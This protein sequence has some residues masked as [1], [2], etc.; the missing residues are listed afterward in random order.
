MKG[1]NISENFRK[2]K[3]KFFRYICVLYIFITINVAMLLNPFTKKNK[4]ESINYLEL[5]PAVKHTH[6]I[7][8]DGMINV[9]IPRFTNSIAKTLFQPAKKST[10]IKANLDEFG[11]AT[12]LLIDGSKKVNQIADLLLEKFGERIEP[13]NE[14]LTMF[15]THLYK[16]GFINFLELQ[17]GNK[18]G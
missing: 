6:E 3:L 14:R 5:T 12:W 16:N 8:S 15:L 9:L 1:K 2:Y 11:S 7:R 18:N 17:K 4:L 13:V 10:Y